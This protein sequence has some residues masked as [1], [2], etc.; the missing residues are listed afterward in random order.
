MTQEEL[1]EWTEK[2]KE[3]S[4]PLP[5]SAKLVTPTQPIPGRWDPPTNNN[6]NNKKGGGGGGK[7]K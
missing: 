5:P 6:N 1:K 3:Y 2:V 4:K 7:T